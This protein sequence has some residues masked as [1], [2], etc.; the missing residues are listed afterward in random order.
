[1]GIASHLGVLLDRPTIG[2]AKNLL[3]GTHE[4]LGE[5]VGSRA[6]MV[7]EKARGERI[8]TVLRTR[9]EVRPIY[10]S[11]GHRVS[12]GSAVRFTLQVCDGYRIPRPP[13][14][15]DDFASETKG[16]LLSGQLS[17]K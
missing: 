12:L 6:T 5:K 8:G 1:M 11:Q 3:V 9:D 16:K 2:C 13:R 15:A 4:P 17:E 14:D 10:V 7:D